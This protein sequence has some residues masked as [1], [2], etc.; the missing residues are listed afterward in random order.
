[1]SNPIIKVEH[2]G[3]RYRIGVGKQ[4]PDSISGNIAATLASPFQYLRSRLRPPTEA[5]VLWALQDIS[6]E[7]KAGE[8]L[9]IVGHNGAGKSTLLKILTRI[10]DPSVGRA[11]LNGRV[12]SLLEVGTG[13]HPELTGREN[14]YLNGTILGMRRH[15]IDRQFDAIVDFSGVEK[16]IDTPVKRYSSG[17][18]V[19]LGFAVAAHLEA[20]ILLIDEVLAVGDAQFQKQCLGKMSDI[21]SGE[22]RTI[23]FVSHNMTALQSLCSRAIWL[24]HGKLL[25]DDDAIEIVGNYLNRAIDTTTERV[26]HEQSSDGPAG[27]AIRM[28]RAAVMP[29]T[30]EPGDMITLETPV[31]FEF[32]YEVLQPDLRINLGLGLFNEEGVLAFYDTGGTDEEWLNRIR[33][34]GR[35]Q[36]VCYVP[37]HF[38]ND[39]IYRI[40]LNFIHD[41]TRN[42]LQ[43]KDLLTFFVN[44]TNEDQRA[45]FKKIPGALET[46]RLEERKAI[47][48]P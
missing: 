8:A 39:G 19:R 47:I 11:V 44:D 9:G 43:C 22:G 25:A 20:E 36:S 1:M 10:T 31:K 6:F 35:Y 30:G 5:E 23:I 26:W 48:L 4:Q 32:E 13:F 28:V 2:L 33:P 42:L 46:D 24:E 40:K 21:T 12:S 18:R 3:K 16:F 37:S 14:I 41:E 38:L 34:V 29:V 7:V 27:D 15:E 45:R 17:M